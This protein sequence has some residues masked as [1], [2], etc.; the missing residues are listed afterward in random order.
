LTAFNQINTKLQSANTRTDAAKILSDNPTLVNQIKNG[1][2]KDIFAQIQSK[3]P[4]ST[5]SSSSSTT[6]T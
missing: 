4:T 6:L 3:K 2:V 5:S 1:D